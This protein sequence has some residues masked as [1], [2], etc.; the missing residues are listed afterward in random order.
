MKFTSVSRSVIFSAIAMF[1]SLA[2][3]RAEES[4]VRVTR[5]IA[6]L[7]PDR[8]E[9]LDLYLPASPAAGKLLPGFVWIHGGGW[10]GGEKGEA[11]GT[12]VCTTLANAGYVAVS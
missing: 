7:T 8:T 5:D 3:V 1:A 2:S 12:E 6:F 11:R 9:K 10:T 4:A